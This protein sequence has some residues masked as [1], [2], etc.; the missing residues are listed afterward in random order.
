MVFLVYAGPPGFDL[1]S[2]AE[3]HSFKTAL[4]FDT[5]NWAC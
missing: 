5:T 1:R 3:M 4:A 2:I